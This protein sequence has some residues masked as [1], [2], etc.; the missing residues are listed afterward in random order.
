MTACRL[1]AEVKVGRSDGWLLN[2]RI[3]LIDLLRKS[4]APAGLFYMCSSW[5]L[6]TPS[7]SHRKVRGLLADQL[8]EALDQDSSWAVSGS[9]LLLDA[10]GITEF[11]CA[12]CHLRSTSGAAS[13]PCGVR[14][15]GVQSSYEDR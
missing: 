7:V 11:S 5:I 14:T 1:P 2:D 6:D 12:K 15:L 8:R 3:R 10:N 13:G 4:P 9:V